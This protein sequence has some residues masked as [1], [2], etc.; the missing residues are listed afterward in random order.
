MSAISGLTSSNIPVEM[1]QDQAHTTNNRLYAYGNRVAKNVKIMAIGTVAI[2][3]LANL[4]MADGGPVAYAACMAACLAGT[5]G[6]VPA[7]V[8]LCAPLLLAPTP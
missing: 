5:F 1:R 7:C 3:A 6:F 2:L 4:P 8:I